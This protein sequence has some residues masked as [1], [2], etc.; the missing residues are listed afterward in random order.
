MKKLLAALKPATGIALLTLL[1]AATLPFR[2]LFAPTEYDFAVQMRQFFPEMS[3]GVLPKLPA[4]AATVFTAALVQL[5]AFRMRQARPWIATVTYLILPPVWFFGTAAA[6]EQLFTLAVTLTV[7]LFYLGHRSGRF[8]LKLV[9]GL[10]AIPAAV[11]AAL[12]LKWEHFG[13]GCILMAPL[14]LLAVS[15]GAYLEKL[16][17]RDLAGRTLNRLT[18]L[19]AF[20]LI[21]LLGLAL[22]AP[23]CRRFHLVCPRV[24]E[25]PTDGGGL[26]RI[27]LSLVIPLLW[28]FMEKQCA[29]T[30]QKVIC[31]ALALG[32]MILTL[33]ANMPWAKFLPVLPGA[34]VRQLAPELRRGAPRCF[35]DS[36]LAGVLSYELRLPVTRFGRSRGALRPLELKKAVAEALKSGDALVALSKREYDS[37]LPPESVGLVYN[38]G[39]GHRI[40]R[41]FGGKK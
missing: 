4:L 5:L 16:D 29:R 12:I 31:I 1:Y 10:L 27:G 15:W 24:L 22:V 13:V 19:L 40:I 2:P 28:C 23:V 9:F 11:G 21:V 33:P 38:S 25:Y 18:F 7:L 20:A 8:A 26:L 3:G 35:A 32:F 34:A 30:P 36:R 17:D 14:P 41:Y 39:S 37:Y 6:A